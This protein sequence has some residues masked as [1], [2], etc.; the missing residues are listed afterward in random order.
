[1][2]KHIFWFLSVLMILFLASCVKDDYLW[3]M[4]Q[5]KAIGDEN[6]IVALKMLDSLEVEI[7]DK[8]EYIQ[9]KYDLLRVRLNDKSYIMPSSDIMIKKLV[10]Y[11]EKEGSTDEKQEV[12]HY[13]GSTYRDLKDA[14]RALEHFFKAIEYANE[15]YGNLDS[16]LLCNSYS[17]INYLQYK[18]QNY[19]EAFKAAIK[20]LEL[21]KKMKIDPTIPFSHLGAS[22][23]ALDK[24]REAEAFY[25]SAYSHIILSKN[26]SEHQELLAILTNNYSELKQLSKAKNCL[27][28]I[29]E[30]PLKGVPGYSCVAFAEYYKSLGMIDSAATYC[31]RMIDEGK[32]IY[33]KYDAAK[34]LFNMYSQVGDVENARKSAEIYMQLSDSLDFGKR[35]ELAAT[36]NNIYQYHLDQKKEQELKEKSEHYKNITIIFF[37]AASLLVCV[38]YIANFKRKQ[39]HQKE[40]AALSSALQR[41]SNDGE[42]LRK[43]IKMKEKELVVSKEAL[44]EKTEELDDIKQKY[45]TA[46]QELLEYD[47]ALKKTEKQLEERKEQNKTFIKLLHQ[48]EFEGTAEDVIKSVREASKGKKEMTIA[49][50]KQLYKA[51][52]ELYPTFHETILKQSERLG[53]KEMQV[54]YLLRIGLSKHQIMNVTNL[55]RVT[56]WRWEKKFE[57][58]LNE[59]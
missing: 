17:N 15:N 55:A 51:V 38:A 23:Q 25:D 18:V 53:E 54:M 12:H 52:D 20:E 44:K 37:L 11:F 41:V 58:V 35:Q 42:Q 47:E 26:V 3:K 59:G 40:I 6:P 29:E 10:A 31:K 30:N 34:L 57:W 36:V 9:N 39:K 45:L 24:T 48:S 16:V 46:H 13:A 8:N 50:W 49:E 5:I 7:R 32:D 43:E 19:N 33:S 14:P 4:E 2:K 28:L 1:M 22:C 21:C 27:E 56:I